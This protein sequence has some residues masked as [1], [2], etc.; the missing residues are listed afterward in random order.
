MVGYGGVV[1]VGGHAS[2][3]HWKVLV[4]L[5]IAVVGAQEK[6]GTAVED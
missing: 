5:A 2:Q 4:R 6:A 3:G 1:A